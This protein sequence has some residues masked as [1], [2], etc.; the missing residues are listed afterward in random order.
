MFDRDAQILLHR[1]YSIYNPLLL[2][3]VKNRIQKYKITDPYLINFLLRYENTIPWVKIK[4][5]EDINNY[6]RNVLIQMLLDRTDRTQMSSNAK[7]FYCTK[8]NWKRQIEIM[9]N[10]AQG[11][12]QDAVHTLSIFKSDPEKAKEMLSKQV[13][14]SKENSFNTWNRYILNDNDVYKQHPSFQFLILNS[15]FSSTDNTSTAEITPLNQKVV[16]DIFDSISA[17]PLTQNNIHQLYIDL[18]LIHI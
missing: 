2:E 18:S 17:N 15:I 12:N 13:N 8:I 16:A 9:Q 6:I 7:T 11:G 14:D 3:S 4:S 1:Y 10:A 5:V